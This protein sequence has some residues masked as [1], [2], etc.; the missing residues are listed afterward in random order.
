MNPASQPAFEEQSTA[1]ETATVSKLTIITKSERDGRGQ[2]RTGGRFHNLTSPRCPECTPPL[3][4]LLQVHRE[5][6]LEG[7][8]QTRRD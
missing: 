4:V 3:L 7:P 2:E 8:E 6:P 1:T 5:E